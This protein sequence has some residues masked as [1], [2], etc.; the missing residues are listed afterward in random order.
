M[1]GLGQLPDDETA[2]DVFM[3]MVNKIDEDGDG[4]IDAD[5]FVNL[6][7]ESL[8]RLVDPSYYE[9]KET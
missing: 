9:V 5:E 8:P 6:I 7:I 4:E 3:A 2:D 1:D